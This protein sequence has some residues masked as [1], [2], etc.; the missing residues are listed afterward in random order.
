MYLIGI[1]FFWWK[2]AAKCNQ[3]PTFLSRCSD[4]RRIEHFKHVWDQ[5]LMGGCFYHDIYWRCRQGNVFKL[6]HLTVQ[7]EENEHHEEQTGPEWCQRHHGNSFGVCNECK[8]WTCMRK[9][10]NTGEDQIYLCLADQDSSTWMSGD[11]SFQLQG[12]SFNLCIIIHLQKIKTNKKTKTSPITETNTLKLS[13]C[14]M[15]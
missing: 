9:V 3:P 11:R 15:D 6:A 8:T 10:T 2:L 12:D 13:L 5:I 4:W 1:H 14:H 7:T